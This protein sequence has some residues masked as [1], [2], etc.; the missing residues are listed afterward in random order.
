[1][2]FLDPATRNLAI[3][4]Q[5]V[6]FFYK[7]SVSLLHAPEDPDPFF[8][9]SFTMIVTPLILIAAQL[10]WATPNPRAISHAAIARNYPSSACPSSS[11]Q[12]VI[13]SA[14]YPSWIKGFTLDNVP[15]DKY[16]M[17]MYAFA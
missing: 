8:P 14:W 7:A 2:V 11:G 5:T 9:R 12:K 4:L 17:M 16:E 1:L 13:S 10:A 6:K 3:W 15:W